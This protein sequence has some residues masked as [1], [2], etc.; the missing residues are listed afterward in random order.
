MKLGEPLVARRITPPPPSGPTLTGFVDAAMI[1]TADGEVRIRDYKS[2]KVGGGQAMQLAIYAWLIGEAT[3]IHPT[4]GEFV[5]LRG[6]SPPKMVQRLD[7][8]RFARL[9]ALVPAVMAP[10][11]APTAARPSPKP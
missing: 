4:S 10:H 11:E 8:E 6:D 7:G 9:V 5:Y 1:F 3:D 2:G